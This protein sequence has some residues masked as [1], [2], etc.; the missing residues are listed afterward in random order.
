[1]NIQVLECLETIMCMLQ[2]C[3]GNG[4]NDSSW[5][6]G[7][8]GR[9]SLERLP[10]RGIFWPAFKSLVLTRGEERQDKMS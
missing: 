7:E 2:P 1:M 10:G 8:F 3:H 5:D 4:T 9:L 6:I